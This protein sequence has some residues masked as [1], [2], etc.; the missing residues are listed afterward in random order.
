MLSNFCA[1][2]VRTSRTNK[3]CM[4]AYLPLM[5]AMDTHGEKRIIGPPLFADSERHCC[6]PI[7][8]ANQQGSFISFRLPPVSPTFFPE[9]PAY[10]PFD[11]NSRSLTIGRHE[12]PE[13]RPFLLCP[14]SKRN[15]IFACIILCESK[16]KISKKSV[17]FLI[18]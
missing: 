17:I 12:Y 1:D 2:T 10:S 3:K 18:G 8:L 14:P 16:L 7:H 4:D 11:S 15:G 6:R 5:L 9:S 13:L